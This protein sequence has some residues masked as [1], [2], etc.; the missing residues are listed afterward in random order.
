MGRVLVA[1]VLAI[2][3]AALWPAGTGAARAPAHRARDF[4]SAVALPAAAAASA[5]RV[6]TTRPQRAPRRFDMLG[7][8]WRAPGHL[9]LK[10]R[11]R[12]DG[13]RW[14]RWVAA[15]DGGAHGAA[16]ASDP[17][18]AGGADSYQ[19]RL[20]RP[21]RGLR[22]HFVSVPRFGAHPA[23]EAA[24]AGRPA[25][26][27]RSAWDPDHECDPVHPPSYGRVD[28]AFVH[29][30]VNSNDYARSDSAAIVLAMCRYHVHANGWWDIGY[31][32][33]VDRY[34]QIFEG[35]AG[36]VDRAVVGA[37][38]QG[39]NSF[40]TG[41]S[42]IGTF[43]RVGQTAA[44]LRALGRILGWKLA[45]NGV[46]AKGTLTEISGGGPLNAHPY[47]ARVRLHRIAGHR[48]GDATDCPG[49]A[50]YAQLPKIR[51]LAAAA[52]SDVA[53]GPVLTLATLTP[54]VRYRAPVTFAG[55]LVLPDGAVSA[56]ATVV[57][58]RREDSGWT[59]VGT[60]T[61]VAASD[62]W[63]VTLRPRVDGRYR[64]RWAGLG[65]LPPTASP[66]FEL[67]V[68]PRL[69][70]AA[71]SAHVAVGRR[72]RLRGTSA[73][74]KRTVVVRAYRRGRGG[75]YV[76]TGRW[77]VRTR[78]GAWT[79]GVRLHHRGL[80]RFTAR[81]RADATNV[82]GRAPVLY[83]RAGPA[84]GAGGAGPG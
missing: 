41:V 75:A 1:V 49:D 60:S 14:S 29:H 81:T 31:N 82:A 68:A 27:P 22:A 32:F 72:A 37:Q 25:I 30:T 8:R 21:A 44:G 2:G 11:T 57:L 67:L 77:A 61:V 15:T 35:R 84:A 63:A 26:I 43:D 18:W 38:A 79:L 23:A 59:D 64:A 65:D 70:Q 28:M 74:A 7:F 76:P 34:G 78:R 83:V 52:A 9:S 71:R 54:I 66:A 50:L 12:T 69:R 33:V 17:V 55:R 46:P 73:P 20:D 51:D 13:G 48:D 3:P 62:S 4:E 80:Y 47:G 53:S 42:S 5:R 36:G 24:R 45:L 6:L 39:Y 58:Q 19:L 40:S 56:G 16:R 10:V